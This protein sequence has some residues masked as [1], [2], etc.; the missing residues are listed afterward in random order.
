M[1]RACSVMA[2]AFLASSSLL[3]LGTAGVSAATTGLLRVA[4][5]APAA[6]NVDIY[7]DGALSTSNAAYKTVTTYTPVTPGSHTVAVRQAGSPASA[8][9]AAQSTLQVGANERWTV[10]VGGQWSS[11]QAISLQDDTSS[12]PA[13]QAEVRFVHTAL[14]VPGVDV[15]VENGP[16]VFHN[17]SFMQASPYAAVNS[18]AYVLQLKATGTTE[19]LFTA[20]QVTVDSGQIETLVG[21]GGENAPVQLLTLDDAAAAGANPTGGADTGGGGASGAVHEAEMLAVLVFLMWIGVAGGAYV[22]ARRR[23]GRNASA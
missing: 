6:P 5:L 21:I 16:V 9:A 12:A 23:P 20:P 3:I 4:Y 11:L 22:L 15:A 17:I 19:V 7:V 8:T 14:E 10:V 13:G 2:V 1:R 18:G